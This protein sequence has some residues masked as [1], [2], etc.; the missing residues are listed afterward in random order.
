MTDNEKLLLR[1]LKT[2]NPILFTGAGFNFGSFKGGNKQIL[3]GKELK[4]TIL[5]QILGYDKTSEEYVELSSSNLMEICELCE[6]GYSK[7]LKDFLTDT[8]SDYHPLD[9]HKTIASFR[10]KKIYT[11]NIDDLLEN[12]IPSGNL[13]V[14]NQER[15]NTLDMTN[16]IEYIKLHG[17][18]RNPSLPYVFSRGAYIDSMLQSRDYR[19][20][21]F[22][23]DIQCN[24]FIF[25]GT[26]YDEVNLDFYL[27]MYESSAFGS[28]KG[29]LIFINPNPSI[30]LKNK[31]KKYKANLIEWTTQQFAEFIINNSL[32]IL[33]IHD[34][35]IPKQFSL[36]NRHLK[37]LNNQKS[38]QSNLYLGNDP[39]WRD[40]TSDWDFINSDVMNHFR[41]I[42]DN[43]ESCNHRHSVISLVGKAMSGKSVY[44][45]RLGYKL[46]Q[47][48]Y[49][50]LEYTGK[51]FD[52]FSIV[53]YCR[54]EKIEQLC[55]IVDDASFY[56]GAFRSLLHS[57]PIDCQL[58]ILSSSR[59]YYHSRKLYNIVTENYYEYGIQNCIDNTFAKEILEKLTSK[60]FLGS[61][62]SY[63]T[64]SQVKMISESNDIPNL[65]YN[66]TYGEGFVKKFKADLDKQLPKMTID[67]KNLLLILSIFE[68]L[69]IAYFPL[70]LLTLLYQHHAKDCLKEVEDFIKF[71]GK[72]GISLR[73]S[74]IA[75][76]IISRRQ[77]KKILTRIKE[78]LI[79]ISPQVNEG[80]HSYW[81]EIEASLM[82]EKMLRKKLFLKTS[83][84][85]NMLFEILSYY[86]DSYNYWIQIGITE[87]MENQFDKALNHFKQAESINPDSYMVQN[88]I[89]R[90]FLKQAN[91]FK[92]YEVALPY[93]EKGKEL[94]L[95]LIKEREEFQVKAYSTHCY[96]YEKMNFYLK[97]KIKPEDK[98]LK[99]MYDMLKSIIKKTSK[100]DGMSKH[101][102]NKFYNFLKHYGKTKI[103]K[104]GLQDMS[105]LS[106]LLSDSGIDAESM[107]EDFE[108]DE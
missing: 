72:H 67:G 62:K 103:I 74:S 19:F 53:N 33:D 66:I 25:I 61:L 98:E 106:M 49:V 96:L 94:M 8:F 54:K 6:D 83:A 68:K 44:L 65:L 26:N 95:S 43:I 22:G 31:I 41:M 87:Q 20:S 56:Y 40:I 2:G 81:N 24:H 85:R 30:L 92:S 34:T 101:I 89:A 55:L 35:N 17:C 99:E 104:I 57:V 64:K 29:V 46:L 48:G 69:E 75:N 45:K 52:Y 79:N 60:G 47:E 42:L 21:Q 82:K 70:E 11:T 14:Q 38:Y 36:V 77:S 107:F 27:K 76:I 91:S 10:W 84:I 102:S 59:P 15:S 5:T 78:I 28:S 105:D 51:T 73:N 13:L 108:I 3:M 9:Y 80:H 37:S 16:R 93:F 32:N 71:D 39:E 88:A 7:K 23:Q 86:N 58:I 100:E 1:I 90:N 12:T 18:V 97:F 50:V 4:E 63:D